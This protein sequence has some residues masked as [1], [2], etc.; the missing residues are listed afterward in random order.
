MFFVDPVFLPFELLERS[1]KSLD[2]GFGLDDRSVFFEDMEFEVWEVCTLV[3]R[4]PD[5][6][7]FIFDS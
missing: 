1:R 2:F 7:V 5:S 3:P 4:I 6:E